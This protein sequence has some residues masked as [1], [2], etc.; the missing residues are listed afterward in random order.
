MKIHVLGPW[1]RGQAPAGTASW[2]PEQNQWGLKMS[3]SWAHSG[4]NTAQLL[5]RES[6]PIRQQLALCGCS[7]IRTPDNKSKLSKLLSYWP[8]NLW[9]LKVQNTRL[10]TD[11]HRVRLNIVPSLSRTSHLYELLFQA[12]ANQT[13]IT[14]PYRYLMMS[15]PSFAGCFWCAG[16]VLLFTCIE[17]EFWPGSPQLTVTAVYIT[18]METSSA[19]AQGARTSVWRNIIS[20]FIAALM[21][22][23]SISLRNNHHCELMLTLLGL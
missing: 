3:Q 23:Y 11:L 9:S 16:I 2:D 6:C 10:S 1:P 19:C 13:V 22:E 18:T 8:Y 5:I 17:L 4:R 7:Q 15:V 20:Y 14:S 21:G 12:L